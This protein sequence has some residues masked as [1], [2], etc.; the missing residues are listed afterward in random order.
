[1]SRF[2]IGDL[3]RRVTEET[4]FIKIGSIGIVTNYSDGS[5]IQINNDNWFFTYN[6]ELVFPKKWFIKGSEELH[7]WQFHDMNNDTNCGLYHPDYCYYLE[8]NNLLEW[9]YCIRRTP[10][11]R[12]EITFEQFKE[13]VLRIVSRNQLADLRVPHRDLK[14]TELT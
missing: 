9:S 2:Q 7:L 12:T 4:P 3:V 1:M 6:F 10:N 11:D 8:G 13:F 5:V 14:S